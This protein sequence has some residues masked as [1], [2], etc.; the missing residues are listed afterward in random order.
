MLLD[1]PSH[2]PS[3]SRLARNLLPLLLLLLLLL[4]PLLVACVSTPVTG[5]RALNLLPESQDLELGIAAYEQVLQGEKLVTSG[6]Q[7]ELVERVMARIAK[8]AEPQGFEW[9]VRLIDDPKMVNAFCLPGGKMA[10]YTGILPVAQDE[11]G[12][13]VVMGHEIAHAVA[14][15]GTERMSQEMLLQTALGAALSQAKE[16]T[17]QLALVG[18]ELLVSL[19]WGRMQESEADHIGLMYMARAGYDPRAAV[20]FWKRM[21]ALGG[22]GGMPAFLSTHPSDEKRASDLKKLMPKALAEYEKAIGSPAGAVPPLKGVAPGQ[23]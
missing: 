7:K 21:S 12:L 18:T 9:E 1:A 20:E 11:T 19:P 10:V 5:R 6:P 23:K 17:Q 8:V 14:R 22:G 3:G 13:A 2:R 4:L 16:S 15:H